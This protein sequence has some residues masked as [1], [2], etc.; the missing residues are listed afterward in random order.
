MV[1][2]IDLMRHTTGQLLFDIVISFKRRLMKNIGVFLN[3]SHLAN[4]SLY[5]FLFL[6][7]LRDSF[8]G[9]HAEKLPA[10]HF[11]VNL[12]TASS[13]RSSRDKII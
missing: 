12:S 8:S 3:R 7:T 6:V 13:L 4:S 5:M 9:N 11:F 2:V 1:K 10:I